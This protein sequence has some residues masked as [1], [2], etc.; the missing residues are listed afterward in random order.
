MRKYINNINFA[1][2]YI[3]FLMSFLTDLSAKTNNQILNLEPI[4]FHVGR[5]NVLT[6]MGNLKMNGQRECQRILQKDLLTSFPDVHIYG[7]A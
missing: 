3:L 4:F 5:G 2:L 7:V 6:M 1:S